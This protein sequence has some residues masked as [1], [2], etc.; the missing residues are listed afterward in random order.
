MTQAV[1]PIATDP[2]EAS[3][4]AAA[5]ASEP[6]T[7]R[8]LLAAAGVALGAAA[9]QTVAAVAPAAAA[10]GSTVKAGKTTT[11]SRDTIVKNATRDGVAIRAQAP[12]PA[13]IGVIGEAGN[14][15]LYGKG[16]EYGVVGQARQSRGTGVF[17]SGN[18]TN[19]WGVLG[20][21]AVGV[22]GETNGGLAGRFLGPVTI[23]G[24]VSVNG[25]LD[26]DLVRATTIQ[27][28]GG[29][30]VIDHPLDPANRYLAHSFVESPEMLNVY[31]GTVVLGRTGRATVRLPRYF[32]ALNREHRYQ[33]TAIGAAAPG[34]HIAR[35]V[36]DGRFV[37]AGGPAGL[38]VSWQV[39]GVRQDAWAE[40]H[41]IKV[42]Y[43]KPAKERGTYLAPEALGKP[44]SARTG[45]RPPALSYAASA[46]GDRSR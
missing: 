45:Y 28:L 33:L 17:G 44:T 23:E 19:G 13:G 15:G 22:Q 37:I 41:P 21:G 36:A 3:E 39:T 43:A 25:G 38:K 10:N 6:R 31:S 9:V 5:R 11:A 34:L 14:Y 40:Q 29:S 1:D 35:E 4:D 30:F 42:D 26:A 8:S 27:K 2:A 7:R 20:S 16:G 12:G 18:P 24:H 32:Q 46:R